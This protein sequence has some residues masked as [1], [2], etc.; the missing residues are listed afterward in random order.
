[1][2]PA[3]YR[4]LWVFV[5]TIPLQSL[6]VLP[7]L[8]TLSRLVGV[9]TAAAGAAVS[10]A[11]GV[12]RRPTE[13][14][15]LAGALLCLVAASW[16][17]SIDPSLTRAAT[18]EL[19]QVLVAFLLLWEFGGDGWGQRGL[20]W[21]W[22][23]GAL[24]AAVSSLAGVAT[25]TAA[26][27]ATAG[28]LNPNHLGL[29]LAVTL[30]I[31]WRL[32]LDSPRAAGRW[33]ARAA[34]PLVAVAVLLTGSRGALITL[35]IAGVTV[36]A[37]LRTARPEAF[38][39]GFVIVAV[40]VVAAS[41]IV[42][43][44][45]LTRLSE[46]DEQV[47]QGDVSGRELAWARSVQLLFERPLAGVGAG[48]ARAGIETVAGREQGTHN[49]YLA[50]AADLGLLGLTLIAWIVVAVCIRVSRLRGID[51]PFAYGILVTLGAGLVSVHLEYEKTTWV[52]LALVLGHA[53]AFDPRRVPPH[54]STSTDAALLTPELPVA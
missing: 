9:A 5:A 17:W 18:L 34:T 46:I 36:V 28:G 29:I 27:R 33:I 7:Q 10:L 48:A 11:G 25:G 41:F 14:H 4:L 40:G 54:R 15:V 13:V 32:S 45:T 30:P 35:A 19:A 22:T 8:G 49:T 20:L 51:R 47:A 2:R 31:A 39:G 23:A 52:V 43:Q 3:I 6:R 21:A 53:Q 38:V 1:M 12:R 50:F 26:V 16:A 44:A 42:P 37:C 24:V